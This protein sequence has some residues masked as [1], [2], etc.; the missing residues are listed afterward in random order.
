MAGTTASW[1]EQL[2]REQDALR[3]RDRWRRLVTARTD[4]T[5][6]V[7][8]GESLLNLAGN[9]YLGLAAAEAGQALCGGAG[10]SR[11]VTGN[12]PAYDRLEQAVAHWADTEAAVAFACGYMAN[13]GIIPALADRQDVVFSDRLNHASIVDGIRLSRAQMVRYRHLD[14]AHL[15]E[16]LANSVGEGCRRRL[17]VTESLFSMDGDRA[18]LAK[19]AALAEEYDAMLVVDEAHASGILG[20]AGSGLAATCGIDDDRL[21]RIFT[22]GKGFGLYGAC[23]AGSRLLC[24][25]IVNRAR[26]LIYTTGL[27]DGLVAELADRVATVRDA[28]GLRQRLQARCACFMAAL[29]ANGL[30]AGSVEGP[31]FPILIGD[32]RQAL[33]VCD[34]LRRRGIWV[35]PIRPPTVPEGTARLRCTVTALH[36]EDE[37]VAVAAGIAE[38][39]KGTLV[40]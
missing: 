19:I 10:A 37:L 27:P 5:R 18:P 32:D 8:G 22:F 2:K 7:I 20:P 3:G 15:A 24:D 12:H 23:A 40:A 1:R 35:T 38:A 34:A 36:D 21:L 31:I 11:L 33:A 26:S 14:V 28:D 16:L 6:I 13:T 25:Q 29:E 39:I 9:D 4:G 17:I 30:Q